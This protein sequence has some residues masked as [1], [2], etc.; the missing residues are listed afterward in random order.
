MRTEKLRSESMAFSI[1][2][3]DARTECFPG[4]E[5]TGERKGEGV[6]GYSVDEK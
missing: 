4:D 1:S 2:S 5:N 3:S 6:G